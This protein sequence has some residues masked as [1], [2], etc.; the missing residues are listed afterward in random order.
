[1][2]VASMPFLPIGGDKT[3]YIPTEEESE[4][5]SGQGGSV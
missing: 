2:K 1:M 3:V 4:E 5:T